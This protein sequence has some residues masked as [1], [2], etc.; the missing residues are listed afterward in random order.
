VSIPKDPG[1]HAAGPNAQ[2]NPGW[3]DPE[4]MET[5]LIG[6]ALG[7]SA[8]GRGFGSQATFIVW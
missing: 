4:K 8:R 2:G 5:L 1:Q 3:L 6:L 7:R